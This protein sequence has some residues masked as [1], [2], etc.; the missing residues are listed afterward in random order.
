MEVDG[1][2]VGA[3][4]ERARRRCGVHLQAEEAALT[5]EYEGRL[6]DLRARRAAVEMAM[7]LARGLTAPTSAAAADADEMPASAPP[8]GISWARRLK[9]LTQ[10]A[11][12]VRI[13]ELQGGHLRTADAT[14]ILFEA[15]LTRGSRRT[16]ER[17]VVQVLAAS[18][19]FRR[20][21]KGAY[22]L[23]SAVAAPQVPGLASKQEHPADARQAE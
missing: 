8:S 23:V 5:A 2:R 22:Q 20:V 18:A 10:A 9:G 11:A 16:T 12:L 6:A 3:G 14:R 15:G 19:R 13:A 1:G 4:R 7:R 21:G 17:H